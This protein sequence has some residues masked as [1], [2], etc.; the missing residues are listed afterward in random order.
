MLF[1][2]KK[3]LQNN[4][5]LTVKQAVE[6]NI[7]ITGWFSQRFG[8]N[9]RDVLSPTL[10]SIHMNDFA[11]QIKASSLG[12]KL[13]DQTVGVLVYLDDIVSPD[14]AEHWD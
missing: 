1:F 2:V 11:L 13:D 8:V 6:C 4:L 10:P 3:K 9:Q 5:K 12:D 7:T 14:Y